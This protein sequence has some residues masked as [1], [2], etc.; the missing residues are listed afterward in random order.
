MTSLFR[1]IGKSQLIETKLFNKYNFYANSKD[2][3]P[4]TI[5]NI[6]LQ[7]PFIFA[8]LYVVYNLWR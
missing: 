5:H 8:F 3:F 7:S 1:T 2:F 6:P 4:T